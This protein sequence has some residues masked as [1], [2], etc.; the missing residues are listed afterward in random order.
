MTYTSFQ[1]Q[2]F[3][4]FGLS[5][6]EILADFVSINLPALSGLGF[7]LR[8]TH[9]SVRSFPQWARLPFAASLGAESSLPALDLYENKEGFTVLVEAPGF[10]REDFEITYGDETLSVCVGEQK[11][12]KASANGADSKPEE[13][14]H[15]ENKSEVG[16]VCL[17]Q[18][19][20][21]RG[22]TRVLPLPTDVVGDKITASYKD[23]VLS[24]WLPKAEEVKPRQ[25][26]VSVE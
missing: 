20:R 25:I 12:I 8:G 16:S 5:P 7:G 14:S 1:P 23:G 11:A 13:S 3:R 15:L 21:L 2:R 17:R 18:E 19:R 10:K 4:S 9:P 6:K 22:F 24:I 26:E